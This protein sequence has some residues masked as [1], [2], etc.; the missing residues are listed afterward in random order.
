V[1]TSHS[2]NIPPGHTPD[3]N[4]PVFLDFAARYFDK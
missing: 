3:P 1:A 4:W 2:G